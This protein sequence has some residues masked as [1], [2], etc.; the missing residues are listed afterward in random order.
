MR[1]YLAADTP[2]NHFLESLNPEAYTGFNVLLGDLD[3]LYYYSN[4]Q[5]ELVKVLPAHTV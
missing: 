2:P 4:L 3:N 1:D 5:Q